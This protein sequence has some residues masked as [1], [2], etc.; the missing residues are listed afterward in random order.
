M[1]VAKKNILTD[2]EKTDRSFMP[3][4]LFLEPQWANWISRTFGVPL[5]ISRSQHFMYCM[6]QPSPQSVGTGAS[7]RIFLIPGAINIYLIS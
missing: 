4:E 6:V 7:R 5:T 3:N 1:L 2:F